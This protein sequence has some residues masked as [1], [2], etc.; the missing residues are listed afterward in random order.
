[1]SSPSWRSLIIAVLAGGLLVRLFFAALIPLFPDEAY[2]WEWSRRLAAGYF[3]HPPGVALLVRG[4]TLLLGST[5]LG[6]R[7][8]SVLAGLLAAIATAGIA[9]RLSGG[10]SALRAA[11][12]ITCMPLAAAGLVLATPDAPLLATTAVGVYTVIR[13]IQSPARSRASLAWWCASGVALGLAFCS[14]YTSILMPIGVTIAII[15]RASLRARLTEPGPY[16]ACVIA[17][18]IFLPVLRW[19][20]AHGWVSFG[21][22]IRHGLAIAVRHD[23]FAPFKRLGDMIG[24]QAGLVSPI[25]F[26][27]LAIVVVRGLRRSSSDASYMLAMISACTFLFFCYSAT[28]QRVEANWPAPA[29]IAAIPLLAALAQSSVMAK[30]R[31][32]GVWLAAALSVVIYLHAGFSLLPLAPR[33]DPIARSAGW[34]DVAIAAH[35]ASLRAAANGVSWFAAD[36]YQDAAELAFH[37]PSQPTTFSLNLSGRSNQ[38]DLWPD[39]A[40]RA[41]PGDNLVVAVDEVSGG[42]N[43]IVSQLTPHFRSLTRDSLVDLRNRHGVV[44]QRRLWIL[45]DWTGGWPS[46]SAP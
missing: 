11:I 17:T 23:P 5:A 6:V 38:Y 4:G 46:R 28:R 19:N 20:A 21:F 35:R 13:A 39:F 32:A 37:L 7:F 15:S 36:R 10:Q 9:A 22:Q 40:D 41:R 45:Q 18:L 43:P 1:M 44:S 31:R 30:W 42:V 29:Y 25:L 14:K 3:D 33:K 8:L 16:V 27:L 26:V 2:Y 12:I 24:G 34:Q